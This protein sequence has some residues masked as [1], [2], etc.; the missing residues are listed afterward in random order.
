MTQVLAS[1]NWKAFLMLFALVSASLAIFCA[2]KIFLVSEARGATLSNYNTLSGMEN[3]FLL[4]E[5]FEGFQADSLTPPQKDFFSFGSAKIMLDKSN[6]DKGK[7][8]PTT[9]LKV[10]WSATDKYG[11]WGKGVGTN[12]D[13]DKSADFLNFRVLV[14]EEAGKKDKIKVIL[15][16]DDNDD[17]ILQKDQDDAWAGIAEIPATGKWQTVSIPLTDFKDENPGGD[18]N[19]NVTRKGGLHTVI[20]SFPECEKYK[21]GREYFFDLIF[22]SHG[23]PGNSN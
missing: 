3:M 11:G 15:E 18:G 20:F 16:E 19:L 13:L 8:G 2:E 12:V 21:A 1:S 5:D 9:S 6:K 7:D 22:F 23:K 14:P 17:G 10:L 4:I